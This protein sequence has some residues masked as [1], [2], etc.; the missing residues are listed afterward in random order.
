MNCLILAAGLGTRLRD[1]SESK[2]LTPVAGVPLIEHVVRRAAAAGADR[3]VVV[4]GH[5]AD[6]LERF[7]SDLSERIALP[8]DFARARDWTKPNGY[9]VLDGSALIEGDYL[10]SMSDHLFDPAI[11]RA[12]AAGDPPADLILAVDSKISSELTDLDDA[13]KVAVSPDGAID[14][15]GKD[16]VDYNA[17]DTGVFMAGPG[18]AK[19]IEAEIAAGGS[20][21]L[22]SG[23]Q[24]LARAGRARAMDV[25]AARWIDVDDARMLALAEGLAASETLTGSAA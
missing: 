18:L 21:S 17:I 10:L 7:L 24:R 14:R 15:I 2:P 13:T 5:E 9:S 25:G 22:S 3:F 12:L 8:I 16:L 20:G 4:T 23:V 19:A 6:R 1:V 11:P